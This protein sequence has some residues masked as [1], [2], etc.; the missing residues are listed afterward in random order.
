MSRREFSLVS[1]KEGGREGNVELTFFLSTLFSPSSPF[2]FS[3][4]A[5]KFDTSTSTP[6][7]QLDF[8][9]VIE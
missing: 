9:T 1:S 3:L 8:T 6:S 2:L 7:Q 5:E 4:T